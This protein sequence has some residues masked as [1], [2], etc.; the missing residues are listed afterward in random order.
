MKLN[1][2]NNF[3]KKVGEKEFKNVND[4]IE[5]L[6]ENENQSIEITKKNIC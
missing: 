2:I 5:F 3:F 1:L 6:E 4:L